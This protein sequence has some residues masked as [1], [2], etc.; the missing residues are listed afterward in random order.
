MRASRATNTQ[1]A[2]EPHAVG[3]GKA[4]PRGILA[5]LLVALL[6][7][8]GTPGVAA[9]R[10]PLGPLGTSV[11]NPLYRLLHVVEAEGA[12]PVG[13][14]R[15][16]IALATAYSNV[17]ERSS[18]RSFRQ[19]FDL[20]QMANTLT[21][22]Y[23]ISPALEVGGGV[24]AV[25]Q[26]GGFLDPFVS[27]FHETFGFPDGNRGLEP[28]GQHRLYLEGSDPSV[29]IDLEPRTL[30]LEDT[31]LF[32]KWRLA[33]SAAGAG[34]LSLWGSLRRAHGPLEPGR[35]TTAA[36]VLGRLSGREQ[37]LH[38]H[39]EAGMTSLE[40]PELLEPIAARSASF[41]SFA[42]EGEIHPAVSLIVQLGATSRYLRGLGGGEL[43]G[44]PSTLAVGLSGRTEGDW[45]WELGFVEDVPPGSPAVDFTFDLRLG[46]TW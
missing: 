20:E 9:Q 24:G 19:L 14:G 39:V 32:A 13:E 11:Q 40:P 33:G 3:S 15:L 38:L 7:A 16:R 5:G 35:L 34:S 37:P 1:Q 10:A 30:E 22:R 41:F 12:D 25:T 42:V 8:W 6:L 36:A 18:G 45:T 31:R 17:F 28:Y 44:I 21:V 23:G 43:E 29:R 2:P 27:G 26:W 4:G 46:R